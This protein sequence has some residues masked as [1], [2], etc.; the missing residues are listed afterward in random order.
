MARP[1]KPGDERRSCQIAIRLTPAERLRLDTAAA[2]AGLSITAYVRKQA[3]RGRVLVRRTTALPDRTLEE[4]RRLGIALNQLTK[5][6]H[7]YRRIDPETGH[8]ARNAEAFLAKAIPAGDTL[9]PD[10]VEELRRIG[11][12]LTQL[13]R[14]EEPEELASLRRFVERVLMEAAGG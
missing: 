13:T 12:N 8:I 2:K 1:R 3:L 11:V 5:T 10:A 9:G 4:L 14:Y 7:T 6:A